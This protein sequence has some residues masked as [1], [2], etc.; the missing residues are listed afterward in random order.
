MKRSRI[1]PVS[2]KRREQIPQRSALREAQLRRRPDCEARLS[3]CTRK[4]TDVHEI[5]NRSQRSTSWLEPELFVSLCRSCHQWVTEHPLWSKRHG[6]TLSAVHSDSEH[7][8]AAANAR[9]TCRDQQCEHDHVQG[10]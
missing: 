8:D 1:N 7:L 5:I 2:K 6:F 10:D 9:V 3:N 4:A